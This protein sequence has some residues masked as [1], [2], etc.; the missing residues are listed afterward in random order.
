M[1]APLSSTHFQGIPALAP[2]AEN[3]AEDAGHDRSSRNSLSLFRKRRKQGET[4]T[5]PAPRQEA[6]AGV[7]TRMHRGAASAGVNP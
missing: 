3:A 2:Q 4:H 5:F 6:G 1:Q 7:A